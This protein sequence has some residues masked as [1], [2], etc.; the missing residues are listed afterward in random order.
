MMYTFRIMILL[1]MMLLISFKINNNLVYLESH[2][3]VEINHPSKEELYDYLVELDFIDPVAVWRIS[4]LETGHLKSKISTE[5]NNLFG[6]RSTEEYKQFEN[7]KEC[8]KYMKKLEQ[9]K[10]EKYVLT[11]NKSNYYDF[12]AWWGYK[13]GKSYSDDDIEYSLFLKKIKKPN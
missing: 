4:M 6:L 2:Y 3:E 10:W 8:V 1:S 12:I 5:K 9:K 7:W 11:T 13:T